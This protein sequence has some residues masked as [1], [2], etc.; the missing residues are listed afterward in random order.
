MDL[1]FLGSTTV[2]WIS[3]LYFPTLLAILFLKVDRSKVSGRPRISLSFS[4]LRILRNLAGWALVQEVTSLVVGIFQKFNQDVISV[5]IPA[6]IDVP[7]GK[8][9]SA[10]LVSAGVNEIF[11]LVEHLSP[12]ARWSLVGIHVVDL[13]TVIVATCGV[14]AISHSAYLG[15]PFVPMIPKFL[16]VM[17]WVILIL[18]TLSQYLSGISGA[19][20]SF[21]V[22]GNN[23]GKEG[24]PQPMGPIL[25]FPM[26]QLLVAVALYALAAIFSRGK[27]L[28][29]DSEGLV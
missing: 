6:L 2:Y 28:Q 13:I 23:N 9:G 7:G 17:A 22:F 4:P 27:V 19:L 16:K 15:K 3:A 25:N 5:S 20:V 8:Q 29:S 12:S 24:F 11:G 10:T 18:Q 21:E 14:I 26:W 1:T